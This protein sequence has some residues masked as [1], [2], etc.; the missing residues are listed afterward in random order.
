MTNYIYENFNTAQLEFLPITE[1][2]SLGE[3][4]LSK[5]DFTPKNYGKMP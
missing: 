4:I 5:V 2:Q 3:G 1:G